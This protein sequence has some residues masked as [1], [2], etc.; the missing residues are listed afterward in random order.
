MSA[1]VAQVRAPGGRQSFLLQRLQPAMTGLIDGSFSTLAP[2]FAVAMATTSRTTP[3]S[4][5]LP[6]RSAPESAWPSRRGSRTPVH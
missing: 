6:P 2:I 5:G 4:L 3:S 1:A